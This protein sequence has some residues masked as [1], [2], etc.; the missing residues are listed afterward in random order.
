MLKNIDSTLLSAGR[1]NIALIAVE[2]AE[3]VPSRLL[4]FVYAESFFFLVS[5]T[6]LEGLP[7]AFCTQSFS[8]KVLSF[9]KF[10]V[11]LAKTRITLKFHLRGNVY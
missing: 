11:R 5:V 8:H 3:G 10:F 4:H 1:L 9:F 6:S 7:H 2:T